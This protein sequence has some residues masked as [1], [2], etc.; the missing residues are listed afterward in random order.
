MR[1][2]SIRSKI[3]ALILIPL[4]A[5][6]V[7]SFLA[8]VFFSRREISLRTTTDVRAAKSTLDTFL[9]EKRSHLALETKLLA[10]VPQFRSLALDG[11]ESGAAGL[12]SD[13]ATAQTA[14]DNYS[15]GD[16]M[17]LV[18]S[19][20][21]ELASTG[22]LK[23]ASPQMIKRFGWKNAEDGLTWSG[24]VELP[25]GL[26]LAATAP[27]MV[28]D[29][30]HGAAIC[31]SRIDSSTLR[32]L[33][34]QLSAQIA[35]VQN[36]N[37]VAC[38]SLMTPFNVDTE[39][40]SVLTQINGEDYIGAY[41]PLKEAGANTGF[42]TFRNANEIIGPSKLFLMLFFAVTALGILF[43]AVLSEAF[44]RNLV[45][46]LETI[47]RAAVTLG[48]GEYPAPFSVERQDEIGVL[49]GA[50]NRM[51]VSLQDNEQKLRAMIDLDPL[52]ELANHRRFKEQLTLALE[53][54][55]DLGIVIF[56]IDHF[57]EYNR[58]NGFAEG[59]VV[60]KGCGAILKELAPEASVVA[61]YGGEEFAILAVG[62][63]PEELHQLGTYI[64][65]AFTGLG[66]GLT[67]S[68]GCAQRAVGTDKSGSLCLAAELA[69][70]QAKQ[71]GR[72]QISDFRAIAQ[73]GADPYEL[74]RFLQDGTIATIQALAAA[75]DAK[76]PY[77]K[78]HSQRVA[79]YASDLCRQ[80][81]G[82]DA[83]VELVYRTG[84]LHDVGK[85]GVPDHVLKKPGP[86]TPEERA[87][88]ET[89]PALGEVIVRKVP[90]LQDTLPGVRNHHE[91]WDGRGYPDGLIGESIPRLGRI[92]AVADTYD[93]MTSDRPY[94]KGL[95]AEIAL[96]EIEKNAGIQFEP[97]LAHAF[98]DMMRGRSQMAA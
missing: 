51:T 38:S 53:H 13:R 46:P 87:V 50:F 69:A 16:N 82:T 12:S 5:L 57:S 85:I 63:T 91:R 81:G 49:Q 41:S 26:Y 72:N 10:Q 19:N 66:Y 14:V 33:A 84:T 18:A 74:N 28:G 6:G 71:L 47:V 78:G 15:F 42:V 48:R 17:I 36:G 86:L 62:R 80:M 56:D 98:V 7:V 97:A 90:Q 39:G 9:S 92:L 68:A 24:L 65:A 11:G 64:L 30:A 35:F 40:Q 43:A 23:G 54:P 37:V 52:T 45:G 32:T 61:R 27:L 31:Y 94:R 75:V 34:S 60:L 3:R 4:F 79:E 89:H 58:A 1:S 70:A 73:D 21:K 95:S 88:M 55:G 83:E 2:Q 22:P 67:L 77:T 59:D 44:A 76:D 93:A 25:R 8:F 20:G 29:Y 96:A